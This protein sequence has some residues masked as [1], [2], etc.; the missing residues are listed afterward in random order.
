LG[1][2]AAAGAAARVAWVQLA[3]FRP[4][5]LIIDEVYYDRVANFVADGMGYISPE[6]FDQGQILPSAE[7]PPLYPLL[8]AVQSLLGSSSFHSHRLMGAALGA[9]TIVLLGLL[10]RRLGGPRLGI[11]VAVLVAADPELWKWETQVLS[12]PLYGVL[13]ALVLLTAYWVRD[14]PTPA[15]G[16]LLGA[17]IG[18]ATLTRPEGLL[19]LV[20]LSALLLW[21]HRRAALKPVLAALAACVL[22]LAPWTIRNWSEF[23]R[24]VLLS[25]QSSEVVAGANCP[26]TYSG[27][28]IGFLDVRC[29]LPVGSPTQ[30]EVER[31]DAQRATGLRYAREHLDRVPLVMLARIGRTWG[32]FRPIATP[33]DTTVGWILLV[34]AIPGVVIAARR[35]WPIGILLVPAVAVTISSALVFGWLRF[36]FA[37]DLTLLVFAGIAVDA[38]IGRVTKRARAPVAATPPGPP[39]S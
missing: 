36:R 2:I 10:A 19:L 6:A 15:R 31:A 32:F 20:L 1:V 23:G 24:P 9:V 33:L 39:G 13:V 25:N 4:H 3:A 16:A 28:G 17:V 7:K 30:N 27:V 11:V 21:V 34:L 8:L 29:V 26:T 18:L 14:S 5:G 38:L 12:E 22:V 35:R 37:A